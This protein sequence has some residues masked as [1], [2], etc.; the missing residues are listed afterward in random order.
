MNKT[1][2]A[3]AL[4][5]SVIVLAFFAII[6]FSLDRHSLFVNALTQNPLWCVIY[7]LLAFFITAGAVIV[8]VVMGNDHQKKL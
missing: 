3:I 5:F 4:I 7:A 8:G 1:L 6:T 2:P